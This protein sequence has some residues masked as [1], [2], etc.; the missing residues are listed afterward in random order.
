[1]E[2]RRRPLGIW[3]IVVI[4]L[5]NGGVTLVDLLGGYDVLA[6]GVR[7]LASQD[8]AFRVLAIAWSVLVLVAAA[9]LWLLSRRG[10]ALMMALVGLGLAANIAIWWTQPEHTQWL[11]LALNAVV[12]FYLNSS[13]VR[14]LFMTRH[15]VSRISLDGRSGV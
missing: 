8:D 3:A 15:E 12:A 2:E 6:G 9:W 10:W 4:E 5:F 1:V 14:G 11:R 13:Q 7:Q